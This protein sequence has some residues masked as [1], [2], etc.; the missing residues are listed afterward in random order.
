MK[1]GRSMTSRTSG[2]EI[3]ILQQHNRHTKGDQED[4]LAGAWDD[5]ERNRVTVI[6]FGPLPITTRASHSPD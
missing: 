6:K 4:D 2:V 3:L 1:H 5:M